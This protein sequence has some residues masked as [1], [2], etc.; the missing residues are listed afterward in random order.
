MMLALSGIILSSCNKWLDLKP[1]AQV[2]EEEL[3]STADG[4]EESLNG[5]YTRCIQSPLYGEELTFGLPEVLAQNYSLT[6]FNGLPAELDYTQDVI[7]NFTN[8]RLISRKDNIWSGLYNAIGN[9][10]LLLKHV[11][12][13]KGLLTNNRYPLIKG[14]ALALRA[15][16]HF[17]ALRLFAPSF[18]S[19]P[20]ARAIPYV[21]VSSDTATPLSTVEQALNRMVEDLTAAK[22]LLAPVDS[23]RNPAYVVNYPSAG[24][25]NT[26]P[27]LFLQNR[28]NRLNYYAVCATLARVYLYK[29]DKVNALANANEVI[30]SKKFPWTASADFINSDEA[31]KDRINYKEMIFGWPIPKM[32]SNLIKRF[33]ICTIRKVDGDILYESP[34]LAAEDNRYK[35]WLRLSSNNSVY[36]LQKYIRNQKAR[37][38]D[39][40]TNRHPLT[41]PALRLSEMFYIAAECSYDTDPSKANAL[42]DSVRYHR[43]IGIPFRP[44]GKAEFLDQ[45]LREARKEFY[46]EGQIFYMYKRLNKAI[47][48]PS[49]ISYPAGYN[50]FVLPLPN[51]EIEYGGR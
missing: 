45:L 26:A 35:E 7:F 20:A 15:Y 11:D 50:I 36:E 33:Q 39:N 32:E 51:D 16:L 27:S 47:L 10:N 14:E 28:R 25:E 8:Q 13:K 42:V 38:D 5:I 22:A 6:W 12:E 29:N 40:T 31:L 44:A 30:D 2:S 37:T 4:F 17:D 49:G 1:D 24:T 46:A 34:G 18:V 9:C 21:T 41:A 43:G 48:G 19:N 23:I 3:F